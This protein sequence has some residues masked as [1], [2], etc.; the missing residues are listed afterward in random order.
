MNVTDSVP[1]ELLTWDTEFF[2]CR[3]ARVRGDKLKPEQA[4]QIDDWSRRHRIRGLYFLSK[5][6]DPATIQTAAQYG[7]GLV[8]IRVTFEQLLMPSPGP[9]RPEPPAGV[10][11]RPV[12]TNDLPGLQAL[13]RTAHRGTRFFNDAHFPRQRAEDL[14]ATWIALEIQGRA[15]TVWVAASADNSLLGY[16]SCHLD[17][18]RREGL[19]GL[20]GVSPEVRGRGIGKN[21]VLT[22]MDWFRTQGAVEVTVVTQGNNR[23][24]QRLYQRCGFLSRDLQL[25]YHKWY[26]VSDQQPGP[27]NDQKT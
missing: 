12:Q 22:A 11:V 13:A 21:L 20:V 7:F 25:W 19:I 18:I 17:P 27:P 4:T 14:Y 16:V 6:D 10:G 2:R 5:A 9:V 24:A 1:C 15:Q 8:D 26:P 23:A 3:I